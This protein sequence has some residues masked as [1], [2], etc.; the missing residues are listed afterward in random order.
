MFLNMLSTTYIVSLGKFRTMMI[1]SVFN[2]VVYLVLAAQL[3]PR[4]GAVGAAIATAV[5]EAVNT[6]VQLNIVHGLLARAGKKA[7]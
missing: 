5:M 1:V 3:I 7:T 6:I 4:Y 2:L